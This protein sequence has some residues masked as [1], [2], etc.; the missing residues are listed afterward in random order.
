MAGQQQQQQQNSSADDWIWIPV[1]AIILVVIIWYVK[2]AWISN[3]TLRLKWLESWLLSP[4]SESMSF[5]SGGISAILTNRAAV[6]SLKFGE[7]WSIAHN[8]SKIWGFVGAAALFFLAY[9]VIAS[10]IRNKVSTKLSMQQLIEMQQEEWAYIRP[11]VGLDLINDTSPEWAPSMRPES[12]YDKRGRLT[13]QGFADKHGIITSRLF[14]RRKAALVYTKQVGRVWPSRGWRKLRKHERALYGIFAAR[15]CQQKEE[16][17]Q[18]LKQLSIHQS[19]GGNRSF[20]PGIALAEKYGREKDVLEVVSR[21]RYVTSVLAG[22]IIEARVMGILASSEFIWLRP[23]DRDLWYLL[24][25]IGRRTPH[26]E[27]AGSFANFDAER[28]T[29]RSNNKRVELLHRREQ[30]EAAMHM[31]A[32]QNL[33]ISIEPD[34]LGLDSEIPEL[35]ILTGPVVEEAVEALY[36]YM[37]EKDLCE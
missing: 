24:N 1:G 7:L 25:S 8:A 23:L 11:V 6:A 16:A 9:R 26:P 14:D 31:A 12:T 3:V 20:E 32:E 15:I 19:K 4:F 21:H 35:I 28:V 30:K 27:G 13:E 22:M 29:F 36:K 34:D 17:K 33:N 2:H 5:H 37:K 18:A 10:D